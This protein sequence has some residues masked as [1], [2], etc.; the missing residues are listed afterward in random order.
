MAVECCFIEGPVRLSFIDYVYVE[1]LWLDVLWPVKYLKPCI[2][3]IFLIHMRL[4]RTI[5]NIYRLVPF[6]YWS[7]LKDHLL[8]KYFLTSYCLQSYFRPVCYFRMFTLALSPHLEFAHT[9][10]YIPFLINCVNLNLFWIC[11]LTM[12]GKEPKMNYTGRIF[13]RIQYSQIKYDAYN[14]WFTVNKMFSFTSTN[15]NFD[16]RRA[17]FLFVC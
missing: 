15:C 7:E 11:P 14:T 17:E 1:F 10:K 6:L 16:L 12:R 13:T 3:S 9:Q 5:G 2:T 4:M 8:G